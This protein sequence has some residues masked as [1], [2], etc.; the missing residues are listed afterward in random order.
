MQDKW[1]FFIRE[2][3]LTSI[4]EPYTDCLMDLSYLGLLKVSGA[5]AKE[6]LQ[7]QLTCDLNEISTT[8]ASLGA[9]C[10]P[11]GR[12][13]SL[14]R[15]WYSH[16]SYY[17]QMPI[18]LIP[19]A[20]NALK[21]YAVFFKVELSD[22]SQD[23]IKIG[24]CGNEI[25]QLPIETPQKINEITQTD[26]F[27]IIKLTQ[28]RY[29]MIGKYSAITEIWSQLSKTNKIVAD[30]AWKALDLQSGIVNLYPKTS[31]KFLPHDIN[32]PQLNGV[33]FNKGC[34]TGQE[35]IA[36]MQYIGKLKTHLLLASVESEHTPQ[37]G[38]DIFS[39]SGIAGNIV[40]L[41][42]TGYNNYLMLIKTKGL[43]PAL[44]L[45]ANKTRSLLLKYEE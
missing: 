10:N 36:R 32:L 45:D 41:C 9:H 24:Y 43:Y 35:I 18:E 4:N 30:S 44:F 6:L 7:G 33:S 16:D 29:E 20:L 21:K 14:F 19:I 13:I 5:R 22:V 12:M 27:I 11:Q 26:E 15:I 23:F 37:N 25:N 1:R 39:D 3:S 28:Q 38:D 8:H 31:E 42:K 40:D 2:F 17:L 34:Y